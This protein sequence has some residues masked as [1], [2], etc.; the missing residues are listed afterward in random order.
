MLWL[1]HLLSELDETVSDSR[2]L[3]FVAVLEVSSPCYEFCPPTFSFEVYNPL[4]C[5]KPIT[6]NALALSFIVRDAW[7]C[8]RFEIFMF[9]GCPRS[10][11]SLLWVLPTHFFNWSSLPTP[12]KQT[13]KRKRS[14]SVIYCQRWMR[15]SQIRDFYVL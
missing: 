7:D 9:C 11:K 6:Q 8:L 12:I 2:F 15:L 5:Y 1:C 4:L 3:C 13:E 10:F 14:G